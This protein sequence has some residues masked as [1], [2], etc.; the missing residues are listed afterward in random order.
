M[1]ACPPARPVPSDSSSMHCD[2]SSKRRKLT[3]PD[4]HEWLMYSAYGTSVVRGRPSIFTMKARESKTARAHSRFSNVK[5]SRRNA[6][7]W[8]SNS[9]GN[10]VAYTPSRCSFCAA[11]SGSSRQPSSSASSSSLQKKSVS[12]VAGS[13]STN[14]AHAPPHADAPGAQNFSCT[15]NSSR[16]VSSSSPAASNAT[17]SD[18][19]TVASTL[20]SSLRGTD[21]TGSV[22]ATSRENTSPRP[23]V[24]GKTAGTTPSAPTSIPP[25][26]SIPSNAAYAALAGR[27]LS[28]TSTRS[29]AASA[30]VAAAAASPIACTHASSA[31]DAAASDT[32]FACSSKTRTT[33]S[34]FQWLTKATSHP[35]AHGFQRYSSISSIA[36]A[37]ARCRHAAGTAVVSAETAQVSCAKPATPRSS[38]LRSCI[39]GGSRWEMGTVNVADI[40][41]VSPPRQQ[42][43]PSSLQ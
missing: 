32:S 39:A 4:R 26:A 11:H 10:S 9:A 25:F 14:G 20:N 31:A 36:H 34:S 28:I 7:G 42:R 3:C 33:F 6:A 27:L 17:C 35:V 23:V 15:R 16:R 37:R 13:S 29:P 43:L 1:K 30:V 38:L 2:A 5:T 22:R 24:S 8:L 40:V 12:Y 19:A 18:D 21:T 41:F